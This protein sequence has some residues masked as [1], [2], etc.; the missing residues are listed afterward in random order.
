MY[1]CHGCGFAE[2]VGSE[3]NCPS[4]GSAVEDM[5]ASQRDGEAGGGFEIPAQ[6][7]NESDLLSDPLPA[8]PA[9]APAAPVSAAV[10]QSPP[11]PITQPEPQPPQT[12]EVSPP[13]PLTVADESEAVPPPP[14]GA[15][16]DAGPAG[17]CVLCGCPATTRTCSVC[18]SLPE[19]AIV[20]QVAGFDPVIYRGRKVF[21]VAVVSDVISIG[22]RDPATQNYP[23]IDLRDFHANNVG[24]TSRKQAEIVYDRGKYHVTDV[25]GRETT[26][27]APDGNSAW[28]AVP[29]NEKRELKVGS[30]VMFG[31]AVSL[32]VLDLQNL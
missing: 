25:S 28:E 10:Q 26:Q 6:A 21:R 1:T 17:K 24:F 15:G 27:Y 22:R 3:I 14:P 2:L 5:I 18:A 19:P 23:D 29:L 7:G 31:E 4:C 20:L 30:R 16:A 11:Q 32:E 9:P 13:P 8:P 12:H